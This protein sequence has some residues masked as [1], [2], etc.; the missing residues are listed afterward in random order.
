MIEPP[1]NAS[2]GAIWASLSAIALWT[3][4][5]FIRRGLKDVGEV[6]ADMSQ[7]DYIKSL[8]ED[9]DQ[10]QARSNEQSVQWA[11]AVRDN[12]A[13]S[14]TVEHQKQQIAELRAALEQAKQ[15]QEK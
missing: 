9:I 6:R 15:S 13:L 7:A 2:S 12:G 10:L 3:L 5:V 4:R 8:K 1:D 11:A 14:A